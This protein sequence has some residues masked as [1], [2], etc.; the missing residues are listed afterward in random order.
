M[1]QLGGNVAGKTP[2]TLLKT[3]LQG[4]VLKKRKLL[5]MLPHTRHAISMFC[6]NTHNKHG[7][8]V[9]RTAKRK[10]QISTLSFTSY[11]LHFMYILPLKIYQN[12]NLTF[13]T[14]HT[15]HL[16]TKQTLVE[17]KTFRTN[18]LSVNKIIHSSSTTLQNSSTTVCP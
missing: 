2:Q 7:T 11:K 4:Y 3:G 16:K 18:D 14:T 17:E 13:T 5:F 15:I 10:E 9:E 12:S 1:T 8:S 6:S